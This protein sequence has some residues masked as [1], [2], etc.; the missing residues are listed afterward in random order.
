MSTVIIFS[1]LHGNMTQHHGKEISGNFVLSVL[2]C[3]ASTLDYIV[4]QTK[5]ANREKGFSSQLSISVC[6]EKKMVSSRQ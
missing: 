3:L 5:K 4:M 1:Y 6:C 2:N